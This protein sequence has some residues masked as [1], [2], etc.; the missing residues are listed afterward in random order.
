MFFSER[1]IPYQFRELSEKGASKGELKSIIDYIG[2]AGGYYTRAFNR[3]GLKTAYIGSVGDD[4]WGEYII[5]KFQ[6]EKIN[7]DGLFLDS[8]GTKR[9]INIM[10]KDGSRK[11]FYDGK[12]HMQLTL[13]ID[14]CRSVFKK[15]KTLVHFNLMN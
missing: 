15:T 9:S 14:L 5:E 7:I 13:D 8:L 4:P 12:G 3:L 2:Q 1:R 11:N 10:Y 6:E